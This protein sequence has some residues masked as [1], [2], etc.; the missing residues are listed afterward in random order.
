M[1]K[2]PFG[3][4]WLKSEG[5]L[6]LVLSIICLLK[7]SACHEDYEGST[8]DHDERFHVRRY[9]GADMCIRQ[10]LQVFTLF[11]HC[12]EGVGQL[13]QHRHLNRHAI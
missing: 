4:C 5:S 3:H 10:M 6:C 8:F 7:H 12:N 1:Q 2:A 11:H 9:R 13:F